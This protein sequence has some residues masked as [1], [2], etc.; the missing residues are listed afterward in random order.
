MSFAHPLL[1]CALIVPLLLVILAARRPDGRLMLPYDHAR[2]GKGTFWR[3]LL[4]GAEMLTPL[5]FAV[6]IIIFSGPQRL[7]APKEKRVMTNIELCVD[8][9][10]SMTT[11]FGDGSRYDTAMKAV[12]EFC[13]YRKGDAFGLTF[14]GNNVLHW[15]PLTS[16]VSAVRCSPPFMQP[17]KLPPWFNG[18]EIGRALRACK[19]ILAERQEGDR[20]ILLI[21]DGES[22]DLSNGNDAAIAKE[23]KDNNI[24]VYATI[25]GMDQIQDEI[26]TITGLTGGDA[27]M[28]GDS[29]ALKAIFKRIDHMKQTRLE[30]AAADTMDWLLPFCVTGLILLGTYLLTLFGIRYTPW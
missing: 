10:G 8:V 7:S 23:L 15:C 28:A 4:G 22:Y 3:V 16:D 30:K 12:D 25:I 27:F 18:T 5:L 24:A 9:S 26:H 13:T 2:A 14:F 21:T 17:D 19:S 6:V 20:M 1:V 11:P 29:E